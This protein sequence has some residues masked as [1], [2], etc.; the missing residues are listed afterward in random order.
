MKHGLLLIDKESGCTSHD[1]VRDVRQIL[2]QKEVGHSGT[3]DPLASGLMVLLLGEATK[4]SH[5]ITEQD[6]A[7]W[8]S[9]RL[10]VETDTLDIT[11]KTLK[12][13]PCPWASAEQAVDE[14]KFKSQELK[15][16]LELPVPIYSAVKVG[17]RKLYDYARSEQAVEVPTKAMNFYEVEYLGLK[18]SEVEFRLSCSKGSFVR[19]W[20]QVL[21]QKLGCGA[22]VKGLR[23]LSSKPFYV[24]NA[25]T[26][27]ELKESNN[28]ED[29][30]A[31]GSFIALHQALPHFKTLRVKGQ[32][33]VLLSNGQISHDLKRQ[34]IS[35]FRPDVD[36]GVKILDDSEQLMALVG[37]EK[38][39]GFVIRRVFRY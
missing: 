34:L 39:K 6:K 14:I 21:G 16:E 26:L 33:Q 28:F 24:E 35:I 8:V 22:T 5:Y 15:G 10:G 18:S 19:S 3:L 31:K 11:G 27:S 20:G 32:S 38:Q 37:L 23:R 13:S 1:V 17:G 36:Q 9:L 30:K 29:F 7:Y 2:K 4:L 25:L 12:E